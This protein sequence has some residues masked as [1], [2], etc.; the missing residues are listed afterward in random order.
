MI[1]KLH[2]QGKV[3]YGYDGVDLG[4]QEVIYQILSIRLM[5]LLKI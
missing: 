3:N 4:Y 1:H 2:L 5:C